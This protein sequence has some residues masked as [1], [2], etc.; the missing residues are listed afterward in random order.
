MEIR[1][2]EGKLYT[3]E[4]L[5]ELVFGEKMPEEPSEPTKP[6]YRLDSFTHSLLI[7]KLRH[8]GNDP[9]PAQWKALAGL[10]SAYYR[11][12]TGKLNGRYAFG[13]PVGGGKTLS[14]IALCEALATMPKLFERGETSSAYE[15]VSVL[16]CASKVE[17][18][19]QLKR[20]LIASGVPKDWIGLYHCY[21]YNEEMASKYLDGVTSAL[22]ENYA[23]ERATGDYQNRRIL[24]TTHQ[25]V[26]GK[27]DLR[28]YNLYKGKP[29]SL[30]IYDESLIKSDARAI[31]I[32]DL[33]VSL[34]HHATWAKS[35]TAKA[36]VKYLRA[37]MDEVD[38]ELK[39]QE[40][41]R[42]RPRTI[43]LPSLMDSEIQ[44]FKDSLDKEYYLTKPLKDLL[45]I[46]QEP[47]RVLQTNQGD[48]F[49]SYEVRVDGD[50][51]NIIILDAS[52]LIRDLVRKYD[53]TITELPGSSK[54]KVNYSSVELYQLK[55]PGGRTQMEKDF[56]R[57]PKKRLLS[58]EIAE[59]IKGI[60][61]HE[62]IIIITYKP[63]YPKGAD[64]PSWLRYDLEAAG[65]EVDATIKVKMPDGRVEEKPR[66]NFL[67]WGQET[68]L[69]NYAWCKN[70][71]QVG[72]LHRSHLEI[73]GLMVGQAED[74]LL[75]MNQEEIREVVR[76]EVR[77]CF[78]QAL[79]RAHARI[80]R[81]GVA[82]PTRIWFIDKNNHIREG[83]EDAGALPEA[84]WLKW[85]PQYLI[86]EGKIEKIA[87]RIK[88][89]LEEKTIS[90]ISSI[91]LKRELGLQT[92]PKM[93]FTEA[94]KEFL[95]SNWDWRL[96]GRSLVRFNPFATDME[97]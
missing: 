70:Q 82:G 32:D 51:Q 69:N 94:L 13:F 4:E 72:I 37:V 26:R 71:I 17:A 60:P 95:R 15:D 96:K 85:K 90:Q 97:C 74:P 23:S 80:V 67:T 7:K 62:G 22:K 44:K 49:I 84:N 2:P 54:F 9:N 29:R 39:A 24:L 8:Y 93:T 65:V 34:A 81:N 21:G 31:K 42:R 50:L 45:N 61:E 27:S 53:R 14:I 46:S 75:E 91:K 30:V 59:A 92:V 5:Y 48:G 28:E 55:R 86:A 76:S 79:G 83:L 12:A 57:N 33:K 3:N 77:H 64:F 35:E 47:L 6:S 58:L 78:Y 63:R 25:R 1:K 43:V 19:C 87:K 88:D 73:G 40:E 68:S 38:K 52:Y 36:A 56:P 16:V 66:L 18:L 89:Y 10:C 11:M 41:E 20:D